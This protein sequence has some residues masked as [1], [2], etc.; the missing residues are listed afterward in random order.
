VRVGFGGVDRADEE[1]IARNEATFRK[2]NDAIERG[3][4]ARDGVVGFVCEC[5]RLGCNEIIELTL[6][7]Y[8]AVRAHARR[9]VLRHGHEVGV[10][11]VVARHQ[12]FVVVAKQGRAGEFAEF[13]DPR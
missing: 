9:F 2:V 8:E 7:E 6:P 5:G 13:S 12:R 10:E 1:R 11:Q 3:H 4:G